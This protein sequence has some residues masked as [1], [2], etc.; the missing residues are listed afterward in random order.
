LHCAIWDPFS[1]MDFR[2]TGHPSSVY[3]RHMEQVQEAEQLGYHQY[4]LIEHQSTAGLRCTSAVTILAAMS[5]HTSVIRIGT[6]I[7]P[8]PYHNPM[9]LAQDAATIDNLSNGRLEF[10]TGIGVTEL[11]SYRWGLDYSQRRSMSEEALEIIRLAWTQDEVIYDGKYWQYRHHI[12]FPHPFQKPHPPIWAGCHSRKTHEFAAKNS[13]G[14]AQN[15]DTDKD[16]ADRIAL[17]RSVWHDTHEPGSYGRTFLMRQVY[18]DDTDEKAHMVARARFGNTWGNE[19]RGLLHAKFGL[20]ETGYGSDD[21]PETRQ[22]IRVRDMMS[23]EN[24]YEWALE[25]GIFIVGSPDTVI[26][27]IERSAKLMGGLDVFC[28]NFEFG[29]MP[30]QQARRSMQMFGRHVLP[31]VSGFDER[32]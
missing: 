4:Y 7:F 28:A 20:N 15:I 25:N 19:N 1:G 13:L 17:Y 21:T 24:G 30:A 6:M 10:G 8:L 3:K 14:C 18:V 22:R 11:E 32:L 29:R 27:G 23:G 9:R 31:V 2:R 26:K 16:I 12:P 5:Q